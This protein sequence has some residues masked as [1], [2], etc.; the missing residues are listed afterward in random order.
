MIKLLLG[1]I[2]GTYDELTKQQ[3][4]DEAADFQIWWG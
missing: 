4:V 2:H 1:P 3:Y